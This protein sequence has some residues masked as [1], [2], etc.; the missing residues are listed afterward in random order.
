[1]SLREPMERASPKI[2]SDKFSILDLILLNDDSLNMLLTGDKL[3]SIFLANY[4]FLA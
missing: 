2:R 4:N 3:L 1:M